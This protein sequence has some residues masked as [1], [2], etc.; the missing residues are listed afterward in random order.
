MAGEVGWEPK[1]YQERAI[2]LMIGQA[3]LGL[4]LDPG[5]GK[6]S[7]CLAAFKLL[8]EQ[9]LVDRMLIVAPLRPCYFVWPNEIAKWADFNDLTYTI[10]HGPDKDTLMEAVEPPCLYGRTD[11]YIIN[12]EGLQWLI[13]E[14][15][16]NKYD[17]SKIDALDCQVLC[18]DESTKFKNSQSKRFKLMR[19]VFSRFKRRWCLT[20]TPSPN[21]LMDLFG[22]VFILDGGASIGSYITHYRNKFFHRSEDNPN[23][24]WGWYPNDDALEKI[25]EAIAPLT[26]RLNAADHL[27]MPDLVHMYKRIKLPPLAREMYNEMEKEFIIQ[28]NSNEVVALSAAGVSTKLRQITNG[29]VYDAERNVMSVHDAKLD[30][31]EDLLGEIDC[32]LILYEYKH[33]KERIQAK[34]PKIPC[35]NDLSMISAGQL[36]DRFNAGAEPYIL[37]HPA[38][39]GHGLNMQEHANHLIW[40]G[41]TWNLELYDQAIARLWRQGQ[42]AKQVFNYHIVATDTMDEAVLETL[43]AKDGLQRSVGNALKGYRN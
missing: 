21:G 31:L 6:T 4:F 17:Y 28:L 3:S 7:I 38:G 35:I 27:A 10:L 36:L 13:P 5:L 12:P 9:G 19:K 43:A 25:T 18:I 34:F 14:T 41:V 42:Q 2:R 1:P 40:F 24:Q 11:I 16:K 20:G 32:A 33:D 39:A 29:A 37:A 23:D 8:K 30:A 15:G 26:L 22:Q